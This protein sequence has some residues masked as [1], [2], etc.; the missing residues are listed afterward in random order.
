M[1]PINNC[2]CGGTPK[3]KVHETYSGRVYYQVLCPECGRRTDG[4]VLIGMAIGA[5][6]SGDIR[7]SIM[8]GKWETDGEKRWPGKERRVNGAMATRLSE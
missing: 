8:I 4:Y 3:V 2:E 6:N 1:K 5:W 7:D